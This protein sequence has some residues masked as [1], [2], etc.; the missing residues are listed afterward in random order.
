MYTK[1]CL[2]SNGHIEL[3]EMAQVVEQARDPELS[4]H[5][6]QRKPNNNQKT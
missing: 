4:L 2:F 3:V 1:I 5:Y 6:C